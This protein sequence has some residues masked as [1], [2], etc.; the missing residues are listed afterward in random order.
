MGASYVAPKGSA[1]RKSLR[2]AGFSPSAIK[3]VWPEWWSDDADQSSSAQNEL[4]FSLARK[5]G[6][7]PRSLIKDDAPKFVWSDRTKYKGLS[8]ESEFEKA[9]LAS[10]GTAAANTILAAVPNGQSDISISATELR[11]AIL[12]TNPFVGLGDL[13]GTCWALGVPVV[14]LRVF[15]LGAKRMAA[16]SVRV[17]GRYAVLIGKEARYPAAMAYYVAHELGHIALGHLS[18]QAALV[19]IADPLRAGRSSG[20][21]EERAA[22]RYALELLTG[23]PDPEIV[24]EAKSFLSVQLA[25]VAIDV[26]RDLA[27][28]PGVVALCFGHATGRWNKAYSALKYIYGDKVELWREV[29]RVAASQIEWDM[30]GSDAADYVA[31]ILDL[32]TTE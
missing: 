30:L 21:V 14:C 7:D 22:D 13:I 17:G 12:A 20:D 26:S 15:P 10:F 11:K 4:R 27:I 1:L 5:L 28:E 19:D 29:N 3:A 32:R 16:M 25:E 6:L 31:T 23:M 24:T 18:D 9:A 8:A 2:E